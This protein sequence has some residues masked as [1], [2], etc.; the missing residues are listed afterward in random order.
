[1]NDLWFRS[2]V[3][4]DTMS[5]SLAVECNEPKE[6]VTIIKNTGSITEDDLDDTIHV[7]SSGIVTVRLF[8][9]QTSPI[10]LIDRISPRGNH[11]RRLSVSIHGIQILS[12]R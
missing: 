12:C 5:S 8:R 10:A 6:L 1:M 4:S 2:F 3:E 7:S 11:K 9:F